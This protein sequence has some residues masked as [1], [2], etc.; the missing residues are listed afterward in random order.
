[1]L[2]VIYYMRILDKVTETVGRI[3]AVFH[4]S[5]MLTPVSDKSQ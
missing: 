3:R 2:H 4:M 5:V 1:M